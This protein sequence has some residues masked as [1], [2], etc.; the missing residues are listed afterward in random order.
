MKQQ[1]LDALNGR[2]LL[3]KDTENKFLQDSKCHL[4][5]I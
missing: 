3:N 4:H 5:A 1:F 2:R